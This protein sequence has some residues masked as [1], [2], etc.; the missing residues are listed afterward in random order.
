M[1][2][3]SSRKHKLLPAQKAESLEEAVGRS[4]IFTGLQALAV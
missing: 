3:W 2:W 4:L 1:G